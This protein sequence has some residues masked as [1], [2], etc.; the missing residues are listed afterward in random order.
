M[1]EQSSRDEGKIPTDQSSVCAELD[2]D[3]DK[4]LQRLKEEERE[5]RRLE[6]GFSVFNLLHK[7]IF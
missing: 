3:P 1:L 2:H 7:N 5:K 4:T 6:S